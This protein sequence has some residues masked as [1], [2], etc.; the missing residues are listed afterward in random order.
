ME[1]GEL[2]GPTIESKRGFQNGHSS[3][4]G[5]KGDME[6]QQLLNKKWM[7]VDILGGDESWRAC[8]K[9]WKGSKMGMQRVGVAETK[10]DGYGRE[11]EWKEEEGREKLVGARE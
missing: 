6:E 11:G 3:G 4:A 2:P 1:A 7:A 8:K 5:M 9:T 10:K